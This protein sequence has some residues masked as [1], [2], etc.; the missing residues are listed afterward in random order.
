MHF[1]F[2]ERV[3]ISPLSASGA[4]KATLIDVIIGE[5]RVHDDDP[6]MGSVRYAACRVS[7]K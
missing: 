6:M 2:V 3:R 4:K 5:H 7:S 1:V